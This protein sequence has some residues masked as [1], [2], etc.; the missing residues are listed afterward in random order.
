MTEEE[1]KAPE[2]PQKEKAIYDLDYFIKVKAEWYYEK[3]PIQEKKEDKKEKENDNNNINENKEDS[4]KEK[5]EE[6]KNEEEENEEEEEKEEDEI[7]NLEFSTLH[8]NTLILHWGVFKE[9][10]NEW[11]QIEKE[12]YPEKTK[13]FDKNALQTEFIKENNFTNEEIENL[14]KLF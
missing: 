11:K 2:L 14:K 13:E 4:K 7:V 1:K 5:I 3:K 8:N 6:P 12:N 9:N 10:A